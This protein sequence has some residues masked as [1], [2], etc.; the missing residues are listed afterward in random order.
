M[1]EKNKE[2]LLDTNHC[3]YILNAK[4]KPESK[5]SEMEKNTIQ[6]AA[7]RLDSLIY[8]SEATLGELIYGVEY[9]QQKEKNL[10]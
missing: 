6:A 2:Y 10:Q 4:K 5:Q 1:E 7:S 3:A 9:S 8:L